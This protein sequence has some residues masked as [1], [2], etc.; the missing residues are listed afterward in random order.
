[1]KQERA[2]WIIV[3]VMAG[4]FALRISAKE[5]EINQFQPYLALFFCFSV[6]R[7]SRWLWLPFAGY[8]LS[9]IFLY[10]PAWWIFMPLVAYAVVVV[11]GRFFHSGQS[12]LTILGGALG[13][14]A[15][16]HCLTNTVS[17]LFSGRYSLNVDGFWQALWLGLPSDAVP[18]WAFLRTEAVATLLFT[19]V[20]L[21]LV[22]KPRAKIVA[23]PAV[24]GV[25]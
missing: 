19:S 6:Y 7:M 12:R 9:T 18:T 8:I 23:E 5:L 15:I 2:V 21:V 13:S 10:G 1:M 3:A 4:L 22:A 17:W 24:A 20:F 25:S 11:W 16:F 14:A